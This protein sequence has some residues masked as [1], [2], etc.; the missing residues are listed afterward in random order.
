[1]TLSAAFFSR[2]RKDPF[3]EKLSQSQVDG[4]TAIAAAWE[5]HGD[6]DKRKLA[7]VLATAFHETAKSMKPITEFGNRTYFGKYDGRES[8]GNN[9]PGDGYRFR[10]RGYVQLTGRRNYA[11]W[12]KRLGKDLIDDPDLALDPAVAGEI[13]VKGMMLGTFTGKTLAAYI[14]K[15]AA[16]YVNARRIINGTD[17]AKLIAGYAR[18]FEA[19]L[20]A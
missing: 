11:D 6:G 8:L 7:Y 12:S 17:R 4:I 20:S 19:A 9:Q 10:G 15:G 16:D 2:V 5:A 18:A 1:M 3:P 14:G 13:A